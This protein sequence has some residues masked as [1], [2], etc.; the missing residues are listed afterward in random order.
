M[1]FRWKKK[2][3]ILINFPNESWLMCMEKEIKNNLVFWQI[4]FFLEMDSSSC[5]LYGDSCSFS[6]NPYSDPTVFTYFARK[7]KTNQQIN[8]KKKKAFTIFEVSQQ[9]RTK[10]SKKGKK[11]KT[12]LR[13]IKTNNIYLLKH[14]TWYSNIKYFHILP[15]FIVKI[16]LWCRWYLH[17]T[18]K[19]SSER[20]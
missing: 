15:H 16:K 6:S 9:N 20:S 14:I 4:S 12:I 3:F 1:L 13:D 7:K 11:E 8:E 17:Y 19:E 5:Y 2:N 18:N 10:F